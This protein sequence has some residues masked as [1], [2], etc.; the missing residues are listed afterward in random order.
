[1]TVT[2]T[3]AMARGLWGHLCDEYYTTRIGRGH[4][5]ELRAIHLLLDAMGIRHHMRFLRM[6]SIGLLD[7][8]Y[9]PFEPGEATASWPAW[10][11]AAV[12]IHE[13]HHAIQSDTGGCLLFAMSY[14]HDKNARACYEAEALRTQLEFAHWLVGSVPPVLDLA[15]SVENYGCTEPQVRF[16]RDYLH[17]AVPAIEQGEVQ[18]EVVRVAKKWLI[19]NQQAPD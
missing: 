18:S 12:A 14:V 9:T 19:D 13:H 1:M 4:G 11:Q 5:D 7:T 8:I 17:M 2:I 3:H 16:V 10:A 6:F 15:K